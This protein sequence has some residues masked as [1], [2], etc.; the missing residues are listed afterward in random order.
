MKLQVPKNK[1]NGKHPF[2]GCRIKKGSI[3]QGTTGQL[4]EYQLLR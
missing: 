3:K 1:E 2:V 4:T